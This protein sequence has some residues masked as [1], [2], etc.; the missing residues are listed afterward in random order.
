MKKE[1][2]FLITSLLYLREMNRNSQIIHKNNY[3]ITLKF[4]KKYADTDIGKRKSMVK[5]WVFQPLQ[6]QIFL[7][8][9]FEKKLK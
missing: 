7:G 3:K 6:S 8:E 1:L 4:S 5:P 9:N 2:R